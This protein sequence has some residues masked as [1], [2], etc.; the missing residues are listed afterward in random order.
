MSQIKKRIP[1]HNIL[2]QTLV[3]FAVLGP[4]I[5]GCD[6]KST[7]RVNAVVEADFSGTWTGFTSDESASV[8]F[9]KS[10][11]DYTLDYD[12]P[13]RYEWTAKK[14]TLT[15]STLKLKI[16]ETNGG[17]DFIDAD[18]F[19]TMTDEKDRMSVT[20]QH[21]EIDGAELEKYKAELK[22]QP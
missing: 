11:G 8:T 7:S 1:I 12:A 10:N 17:D 15:D 13:Y 21:D 18:I 14:V 20:I 9:E 5:C 2:L 4:S 22:K 19:L 6:E 3:L 16:T